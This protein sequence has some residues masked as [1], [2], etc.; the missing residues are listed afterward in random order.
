[1]E[2]GQPPFLSCGDWRVCRELLGWVFSS[3]SPHLPA[4]CRLAW[5]VPWEWREV[6]WPLPS[7]SSGGREVRSGRYKRWDATAD[8]AFL[9]KGGISH[10]WRGEATSGRAGGGGELIKAQVEPL[11][12]KKGPR[13]AWAFCSPHTSVIWGSCQ[14]A[15]SDSGGQ[16]G[17]QRFCVFICNELPGDADVAVLEDRPGSTELPARS[18]FTL[19]VEVSL[20]ALA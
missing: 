3:L 12:E 16:G 9:G 14:K 18:S 10:V 7:E 13:V 4:L 5:L 6:G 15:D 1:M 19:E 20:E 11:E 8:Q 2:K 17:R